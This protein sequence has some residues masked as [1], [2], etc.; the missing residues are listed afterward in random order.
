MCAR[1]N[2]D[3]GRKDDTILL[4]ISMHIASS[5]RSD[6]LARALRTNEI[7]SSDRILDGARRARAPHTRCDAATPF[8]I[9]SNVP[10][11]VHALYV[12]YNS[13]SI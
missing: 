8:A 5:E 7:T 6:A 3:V 13:H 2:G 11:N 12:W 4:Y 10:R 9:I 1:A